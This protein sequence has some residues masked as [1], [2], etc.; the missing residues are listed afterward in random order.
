MPYV[1]E[2]NKQLVP[3][4]PGASWVI[5]TSRVLTAKH[6]DSKV[7][8]YDNMLL[9]YS[10]PDY[11]KVERQN[12]WNELLALTFP[13]C[14][15][16]AVK[17]SPQ[18]YNATL[19][20]LS[21]QIQDPYIKTKFSEFRQ[22]NRNKTFAISG[23][24]NFQQASQK[25]KDI[26]TKATNYVNA[27]GDIF[28][29]HYFNE[30]YQYLISQKYGTELGVLQNQASTLQR[31]LR[32]TNL[33]TQQI[34]QKQTELKKVVTKLGISLSGF[35]FATNKKLGSIEEKL[36]KYGNLT[37]QL[38]LEVKLEKTPLDQRIKVLEDMLQRANDNLSTPISKT[39]I[40]QYLAKDKVLQKIEH[41]KQN[42]EIAHSL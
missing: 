26:D 32:N 35:E 34:L 17:Q 16:A 7:R 20:G 33:T 12:Q 9:K 41:Q 19:D 10:D 27:S 28:A 22:Q 40:E 18:S 13:E 24:I 14:I 30:Q 36:L 2:I 37:E 6:P 4:I 1:Y 11:F 42:L 25:L 8:F 39:E 31:D 29:E 21:N 3:E 23:N 15:A 38:L 5:G